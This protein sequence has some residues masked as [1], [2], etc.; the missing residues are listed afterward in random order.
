MK[1]C[2]RLFPVFL[3]LAM[4]FFAPG[5][6]AQ[7]DKG[8]LTGHVTDSSGSI[9]QG[10]SIELQPA[11]VTVATDQQGSYF[12]NNL[13][14]GTYTITVTYVGF[15]LFTKA[16]Q[17]TAGQ[18][19]TV[20]A[21]ME[22]SSQR[23]EVLVTADRVSGEAEE[24]NRQR[25]ADNILQV[26]SNEVI[27]SLP[28]ANIADAVGRLPSVTL[29]R[30]E[31]E[32]KYV[33]VRGTEPRLTNATID[34][35]NVPSPESGV[36]Q[37]KFDAIP[38][39]IVESVEIN[40][41]LQANQDA[42]GIG[43]SVNMVTKT[44]TERPTV[45]IFGLGGI[46]PILGG[47]NNY[48]TTATVGQRF[49]SSKKFG[50][51]FGFSYDYEGRGIDDVE[52]VP[53]ELLLPGG[54][55]ERY[56]DSMDIRE[57]KYYR[58]RYGLAGSTDYQLGEGS[59]IYLR[60]LFSDFHNFGDR[61]VYTLNDN[62]G[63]NLLNGSG[64]APSFNNSIRRP[65]YIIGTLVLGGKH[66]L[67]STWFSWDVSGSFASEN[68]NG[69]GGGSFG[70]PYASTYTSPCTYDPVAT[71]NSLRPL[72][73][74]ACYTEAYN[75]SLFD[76]NDVNISRGKT[77]Q[78]NI[79]AAGAM[80]KR[81]HIGSHLAMIEIGGKFRNAHKY[82]HSYTDDYAIPTV[83]GSDPD[84]NDF[85][86]GAAIIPFSLFPSTFHNSN[87][88]NGTYP[89]GPFADYYK[90]QAYVFANPG[91]FVFTTG[92]TGAP[93]F[94]NYIE[95]VSAGYV[96]NTLDFNKFRLIAGVRVEGTNLDTLSWDSGANNGNGAFTYKAGGD[97]TKVLPSASLRYALTSNTDFRLV[98]SRALS[99]PNPTDV[100]QAY[101][102]TNAQGGTGSI[103]L[104]N[105]DLKAETA[106]NYDI[107]F[108]HYM[109]PFGA[110]Q[111]GLFYKS[112]YSP[113]VDTEYVLLNYTPPGY[114][115]GR[116]VFS[117]PVNAGSA[118][119][120]GFE[121]AYLQHF[122]SLPGFLRG[123]GLSGNYSYTDSGVGGLY[124]RLD[125][126]HLLR[127]APNTWN[128]SPTYD[129][130]R[131]SYRLG[132]SYNAANIFGYQY[133]D[134][135]AQAT[136]PDAP[137]ATPGGLKGPDGDTYLYAHLQIDMQG[138]ARLEKGFTFVA[139]IL[140]ANNE[141][142]GFYNGS[143]QYLIQRE[144]YKPTYAL[145]LRWSPTTREK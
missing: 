81:Y 32:G 143:S 73:S 4:V 122:S 74:P 8:S 106:N 121:I 101:S 80:G 42:D 33:Q 67:A 50:T 127:Q 13:T 43:G 28:N 30:D 16:V 44:A 41:T 113:I 35:V 91:Q 26:L 19:A 27:T 117:Q 96:M 5:A 18:T 140:N 144:Y 15:S 92:A 132:L 109:K 68:D 115:T 118:H 71:G 12:V 46:S 136:N 38:S 79:Q 20:D 124:N 23:D 125:H 86:P 78:T 55:T 49:G 85:A 34:G 98:Y 137:G 57:Y 1:R 61:W 52:P 59:N 40:K 39:D 25:T 11:G 2:I 129:R 77:A 107:L 102:V 76:L 99:R 134:G 9:L 83:G 126:P 31:G 103:S 63:A 120:F 37:I 66:V 89:Q 29:E 119:L 133:Q 10:A 116:Y 21:K 93:N 24:V 123:L 145:G 53:D 112:L 108:E 114:T 45:S 131:F 6:R 48:Q 84:K 3:S 75:P 60:G 104:G 139:Y 22:V 65:R 111:A 90:T 54:A 56:F 17:I 141:V 97:Y 105:K 94:Y 62:S 138:S 58:T 110:I 87:Y 142:F 128:I 130:G 95:Q 100:A 64:G 82:D 7:G 70:V 14:A 51:L 72:W 69:Y 47:R 135:S 36:R 88:Y